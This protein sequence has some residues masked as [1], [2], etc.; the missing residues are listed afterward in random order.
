MIKRLKWNVIHDDDVDAVDARS[1][2]DE[3]DRGAGALQR[4][5]DNDPDLKALHSGTRPRQRR[6]ESP[7]ASRP[8]PQRHQRSKSATVRVE[9]DTH[10]DSDGSAHSD[11]PHADD[12]QVY[13]HD[14]S[15]GQGPFYEWKECVLCSKQFYND[16]D[17]QIHLSAK[18]HVEALRKQNKSSNKQ[19]VQKQAQDGDKTTTKTDNESTPAK[20]LQDTLNTSA[21]KLAASPNPSSASHGAVG[22]DN[23]DRE[24]RPSVENNEN[25]SDDSREGNVPDEHTQQAQTGNA[26]RAPAKRRKAAAKRK[27]K[28]LKRRKWEKRRQDVAGGVAET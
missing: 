11:A 28:A 21:P 25:V 10:S 8:Q 16:N 12:E 23:N 19:R 22:E 2:S 5:I 27:L 13:A 15:E 26:R 14:G 1:S 4:L 3:S 7:A 9:H 18:R 20:R 6:S 24:T 17:V